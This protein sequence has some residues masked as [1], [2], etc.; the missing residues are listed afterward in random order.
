M[1]LSIIIPTFEEAGAIERTLQNLQ[2]L[3][4]ISHEIIVADSGSTDQTVEI[5]KKYTDKVYVYTDQPK[6]ASRGRNLGA[7]HASGEL[8][9]FIDADVLPVNPNEFFK[10]AIRRFDADPKL[11][12]AGVCVRAL[13]EVETWS[14]RI[15]HILVN[16]FCYL[17]NN[18]LRV[19]GISG[20]FQM[21]RKDAFEKVGKYNEHL[22]ITEDNDL[23]GRLVKIGKTRTFWNLMVM[24]P[25]R[26]AHAI[27]WRRLWTEWILNLISVKL[28]GRSWSDEWLHIR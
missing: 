23:Y 19:G 11:V 6:N 17:S 16:L 2:G 10:E 22:K 1:K 26:R 28:R 8:L 21:I 3:G 4:S 13:P 15:S 20:E 5:A 9:A 7:L 18:I 14:D 27:G 12:A 24:H 25:S